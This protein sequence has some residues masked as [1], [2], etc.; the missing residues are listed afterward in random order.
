MYGEDFFATLIQCIAAWH[1]RMWIDPAGQFEIV[2]R[3]DGLA[4]HMHSGEL[5][6][7][8]GKLCAETS[9][10]TKGGVM[11]TFGQKTLGVNLADD[12]LF[13]EAESLA[14]GNE[15]AVFVDEG[16]PGED[17]ILSALT[18]SAGAIYIASDAACTLLTDK[19]K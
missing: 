1:E 19:G 4:L 9:V 13:F 8:T 5:R 11:A 7:G 10:L 16:I 14:A 15:G 2:G 17:Y 3:V 18:E 12:H 6:V